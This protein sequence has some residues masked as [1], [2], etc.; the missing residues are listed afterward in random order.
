MET[1]MWFLAVDFMCNECEFYGTREEA[2][3]YFNNFFP[4]WCAIY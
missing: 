1:K 4:D 3:N 2:E